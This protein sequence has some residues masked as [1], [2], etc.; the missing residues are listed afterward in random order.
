MKKQ[1]AC[2]Q[3]PPRDADAQQA[4][5]DAPDNSHLASVDY[6]TSEYAWSAWQNW[7]PK[8]RSSSLAGELLPRAGDKIS[9]SRARGTVQRVSA[10]QSGSGKCYTPPGISLVLVWFGQLMSGENRSAKFRK[11]SGWVGFTCLFSMSESRKIS[12]QM[13]QANSEQT[14]AELGWQRRQSRQHTTH[15]RCLDRDSVLQKLYVLH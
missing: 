13:V 12:A 4:G 2:L 3:H 14:G 6:P 10:A 9:W 11:H 7:G 5:T 1:P 8:P 15:P